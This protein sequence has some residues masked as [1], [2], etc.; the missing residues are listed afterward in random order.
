MPI[1]TLT[2]DWYNNDYYVGA[3]KGKILRTCPGASI[4]DITHQIAPFN[5]SQAAFVLKNCYLEFPVGTIHI[6]CVNSENAD[7]EP[8]VVVKAN[9]HYFIS[10]DNGLYG[11][12]LDDDAD[13][14]IRL[15]TN[16]NQ[17]GF[18]AFGVL[19]DAACAL[20]KGSSL[21]DL[22]KPQKNLNKQVPMLPA[23]D[24]AVINGSVV[25]IDS[26]RNAITNINRELFER[27]GKKRKFEIYIQSNHY[28]V[29]KL[30]DSYNQTSVGDLL[31]MFNSSGYLEV[32]INKGN[33]AD[34][35]NLDIG[36]V[37]RVKFL[38]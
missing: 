26:Y 4:I 16:D 31:A 34:L 11:L 10:S 20:I 28:K 22:G 6:I 23:I 29:R 30:N 2:S 24:E 27:V 32:A 13:D 17:N 21:Q 5:I 37:I 14:L 7:D 36:S 9:G 18:P 12:L 19:A 25:Y 8:H 38:D 1:I 3:V 15:D 33:A 35:L